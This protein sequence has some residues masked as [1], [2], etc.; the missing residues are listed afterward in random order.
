MG[1]FFSYFYLY[2]MI[3]VV[4]LLY[5]CFVTHASGFLVVLSFPHGGEV[6]KILKEWGKLSKLRNQGH[7]NKN[8]LRLC[9]DV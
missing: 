6:S 8:P 1:L 7:E 4:F 2:R 3:K 9:L 5:T